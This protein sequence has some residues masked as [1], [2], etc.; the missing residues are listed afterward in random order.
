MIEINNNIYKMFTVICIILIIIMFIHVYLTNNTSYL[1]NK[2]VN[3]YNMSAQYCFDKVY[4]KH[5]TNKNNKKTNNN[6]EV[7]MI[8]LIS[9]QQLDEH[10]YIAIC[11]GLKEASSKM[12]PKQYKE[13]LEILEQDIYS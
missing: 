6:D 2:C 11:K 1:F 7:T 10:I 3:T 9:K 5:N 8:K 4:Y 13:S 12:T